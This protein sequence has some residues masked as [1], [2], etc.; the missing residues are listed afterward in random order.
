MISFM[1]SF[2]DVNMFVLVYFVNNW[3]LVGHKSP[4]II[5]NLNGKGKAIHSP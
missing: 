2:D 4:V 3:F 5:S 1:M